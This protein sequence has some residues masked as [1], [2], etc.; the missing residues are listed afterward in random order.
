M[1]PGNGVMVLNL[2]YPYFPDAAP[3]FLVVN[4]EFLC[5]TEIQIQ[6]HGTRYRLYALTFFSSRHYTCKIYLYRANGFP[7]MT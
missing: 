6:F 2:C 1:E 3:L 5:T 4:V 7:M